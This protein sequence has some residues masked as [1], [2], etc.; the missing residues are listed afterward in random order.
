MRSAEACSRRFPERG[1]HRVSKTEE[2]T[3]DPVLRELSD[4]FTVFQWHGAEVVALPPGATVLA[5]NEAC[6]VQAFRYGDRAY[7]VQFHI[8]VTKETVADWAPHIEKVMSEVELAHAVDAAYPELYGVA[9][10]AYDNLKTLWTRA[11]AQP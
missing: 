8:E 7:G 11:P 5:A 4:P 3:H 10:T 2:G 6:A 1:L 9:R